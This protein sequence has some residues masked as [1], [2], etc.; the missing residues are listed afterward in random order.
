MR[1]LLLVC[2]LLAALGCTKEVVEPESAQR[3]EVA[4]QAAGAVRGTLAVKLTAE[5]AAALETAR[6]TTRCAA[7]RSGPESTDEILDKIGAVRFERIIPYDEVFEEQHRA[8]GLH[9]WYRI[10]FDDETS[11]EEVGKL[12][13][14][15]SAVSIVEFTHLYKPVKPRPIRSNAR[16]ADYPVGTTRVSMPMNDPML[17]YQWHFD[18]RGSYTLNDGSTFT[19]IAA[20]ADIGLFNAWE[21]STGDPRVVVA[22]LDEPIQ[23]THPDLQAN[24][25]TNTI[26]SKGTNGYNFYGNTTALDWKTAD[27]DEDKKEY[28]YADHGS[29][30]AG[31]IAATNGNQL[32]VC[33]IAGG[34]NGSGGVK[35]MSCQIMGNGVHD[36]N[37]DANY[38]AFVYAA[39]HGAVIAQNSWGFTDASGNDISESEWNKTGYESLRTG[40]TYFI[41]HAGANNPRFP[42]AP[43]KGGLIIFAA[44]NSGDLIADRKTWP[45][46]Y[47]S[48]VAVGSMGWNFKPAYYTNYG[49]WVDITAPGGDV[50]TGTTSAGQT[51]SNAQVLSTV[52]QDPTMTF[53][54]GRTKDN[55]WLG[56]EFM[57]GTSMACPHVSGVAALGL[58][59]AAQIGKQYTAA[60]FKSLL[61]SSVYGIDH[62]F[63]GSNHA[64]ANANYVGKMGGGC[65]DAL[66]LL[67]SIKG[68][69]AIYVK[70][71][72]ASTIDFASYLGGTNSKVRITSAVLSSPSNLGLTS[73]TQLLSGTTITL[74]CPKAGVSMLTLTAQSGDSSFTRE[75]AI[76]SRAG[77]ASNNGWL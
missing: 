67:L 33:G 46:G 7:T 39:D 76:V 54:D 14:A 4:G 57:Q 63:T 59:Y 28:T 42:D 64:K 3:A 19:Q 69:P 2:C 36:V 70:T 1:R 60:E 61:L 17:G 52:L 77:L 31:I 8:S 29:H 48:V 74:S 56:Y 71:S 38:Q 11:L 65:V 13:S 40:M 51:Y 72:T 53:K 20:G 73:A 12:L 35:L 10:Y 44:G 30:V 34:R 68:T 45:G 5:A 32:G 62:Y 6:A 16:R 9:L 23:T 75:F 43:L 15:D 26:D 50:Y 47:A 22:V 18:N 66:K 41:D 21:L 37:Y 58:S 27:Y 49:S 24:I 55:S 25:W